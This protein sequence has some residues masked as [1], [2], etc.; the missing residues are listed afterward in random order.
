MEIGQ[1]VWH[2]V[3]GP[4]C[5]G[6]VRE[7]R[8]VPERDYARVHWLGDCEAEICQRETEMDWETDDGWYQIRYLRR[9]GE[10]E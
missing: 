9:V 5:T 10:L 4:E 8:A 1:A 6:I 7:T 2:V 3:T